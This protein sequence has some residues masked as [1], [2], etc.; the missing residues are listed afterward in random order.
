M[1]EV[2]IS[3]TQ[4]GILGF[5]TNGWLAMPL[6]EADAVATKADA[7]RLASRWRFKLAENWNRLT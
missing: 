1:Q 2:Y 4:S 5:F 7:E 3:K 6:N